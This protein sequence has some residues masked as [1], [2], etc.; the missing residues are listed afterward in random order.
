VEICSALG[1]SQRTL[2]QICYEM[3]GIG[4]K[5]YLCLRRLHLARQEL[6]RSLPGEATVTEVATKYG[7][8]ELGR[9]AVTYR[10]VF[11]ESPS[12]TLRRP[13]SC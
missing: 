3:L 8:W 13:V 11:G 7:F 2:H 6:R 5:R 4:P 12:A 10:S 1:V 9:F